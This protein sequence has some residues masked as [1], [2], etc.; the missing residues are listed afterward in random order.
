MTY[1]SHLWLRHP[2]VLMASVVLASPLYAQTPPRPAVRITHLDSFE[3]STWPADFNGDGRTDLIGATLNA[4]GR[5]VT[6]LVVALGRGDGTFAPPTTL[7]YDAAPLVV[8]DFNGDRR[9]D[10]IVTGVAVLPGNGDGTF[11]SARPVTGS[12]SEPEIPEFSPTALA[13]D[14]NADGQRDL[15][16]LAQSTIDI[17][18]GNG[19]LTFGPKTSLPAGA[20]VDPVRSAIAADFNGDSRLDIAAV[21][22]ANLDIYLNGGGFL[23]S[24][25]TVSLPGTGMDVTAGDLNRDTRTDV[26]VANPQQ[27]TQLE[28]GFGQIYTLLGNGNGTFQPAVT[29]EIGMRG[30][31]KVVVGDFNTDGLLDVATGNQSGFPDDWGFFIH[32]WDSVSIL[33]GRG[34]GTF[35]APASFHLDYRNSDRGSGYVFTL[36]TL[37]ISDVNADGRTDL[38]TSPGAVLLN[39]SAA[40]N[41]PPV[42]NAGPDQHTNGAF[43]P[44]CVSATVRDPDFDVLTVSWQSSD[45][46]VQPPDLPEFCRSYDRTVT[47]RATVTDGRGGSASNELVIVAPPEGD[48]AGVSLEE[49]DQGEM[50]SNRRPFTVAWAVSSDPRFARF[51]VSSSSDDGRT[52]TPIAECRTLPGTARSCTWNAPAPVTE[53]AR[54]RLDVFDSAGNPVRFDVS[55]RFRIVDG[56]STQLPEGWF[57]LDLGSVGADGEATHVDGTFTVKGSGA[58]I[59][60]TEDAF[61]YALTRQSGNFEFVARVA[62]VENVNQ[63]TK[64]GLMI[65]AGLA[66]NF[67]HASIFATPS[68]VKGVSVQT[69]PSANAPSQELARVPLAPPVWLR[70]TRTGNTVTPAYRKTTADPWTV[71]PAVTLD[72][73]LFVDV[74]FAVS[75]HVDG[76]LATATFTDVSIF[77]P[78]AVI[79][80]SPGRGEVIAAGEPSLIAWNFS[81]TG[82]P[83]QWDVRLSTDGGSTFEPI[84]GCSFIPATPRTCTWQNPGP[85]MEEAIISVEAFDANGQSIA[86]GRSGPFTIQQA[87]GPPSVAFI[88]PT[89]DDDVPTRFPVPVQWNAQDDEGIVRFDIFAAPQG[90][91]FTA[92][93][94]CTNLPGTAR[95]CEWNAPQVDAAYELK[96]IATDTAGLQ[97]EA[98]SGVFFLETDRAPLPAPWVCGDVGAVATPGICRGID[99]EDFR[100]IE[101]EG[102]GADIWNRA[103]EF[104]F[105]RQD[106][107]GDFAFTARVNTVENVNRWTKAGLMIRDF[108]GGN[109]GSRH[110]SFFVTPTTEKGTAF[111]RRATTGGL[112]VHTAGPVTTAPIWLRLVRTGDVIRAFY[113]RTT[114]DPWTFVGE[115]RFTG[116]PARLSAMLV[117]S[118]HV[119]GTLATANFE[120]VV[121]DNLEP[122]QSADIG[123]TVPGRTESNSAII[124]MDGDGADIW[125]T[126]DAFR[127]HYTPWSGDGTII[128]RVRSIENTHAWAKAGVMIR[129]SL[130]AG[131]K[132]AMALVSA[133]KGISM[134]ARTASGGASTEV[135]RTLGTAPAWIRLTRQGDQISAFY[136]ID[137]EVSP[138]GHIYTWE[139]LGGMTLPMNASVFIGLAVTSHAP[140]TLATAV[141]D[142]VIVMRP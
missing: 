38:I 2:T 15:A 61:Q 82:Q 20:D 76:R 23:F 22:G 85:V 95:R 53:D 87:Q 104:S 65:R 79:V 60:G 64:A 117:V 123:A 119:D 111:Q 47:L 113:R 109:A 139:P 131:S 27:A 112:S 57:N 66:S 35:A 80:T 25:T 55:G 89:A 97:G 18:P 24:R 56:P 54:I 98:R 135:M 48:F 5:R 115:Q 9:I 106:V 7:P 126:A 140:G 108:A 134:Q 133:G 19:D 81:G 42:I 90:G 125:G 36:N 86:V 127:F 110:A 103:D 91:A 101:V 33:A 49:P 130:A 32:Y 26:I 46:A 100:Q 124:T 11:G 92:I 118:S 138:D 70:L 71:L 30:S 84:A 88:H 17:H 136:A 13:V 63:W 74:G 83:Q 59:W 3:W 107:D 132:H 75:S 93:P 12:P 52:F 29:H 68:T 28:F 94:E 37:K 121:V 67:A 99:G 137:P 96:I 129:E 31:A 1:P 51:E 6:S 44:L 122:M 128:A 141:F 58:D 45:P 77:Q 21:A 142:D 8:G 62:S 78:P 40:A 50:V 10:V 41:R 69:R 73:G 114:T 43:G 120:S 16:L 105:A 39:L 4:A 14:F 116:L 72:I 102:S 34:D